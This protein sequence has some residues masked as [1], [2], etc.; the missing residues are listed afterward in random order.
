MFGA[1]QSS[2]I[3]CKRRIDPPPDGELS[4]VP[5][6]AWISARQIVLYE[7]INI[8]ERGYNG[9][10][11]RCSI[12]CNHDWFSTSF[13]PCAFQHMIRK[14]EAHGIFG[15]VLQWLSD[16]TK[17][18]VQRVV[19]N[20]VS[21]TWTEVLSSVVQG[22]VLGPVLFIVFINDIDTVNS[23]TKNEITP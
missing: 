6:P 20:G 17:H 16:W 10:G 9:I 22:S 11:W 8:F 5:E 18:R 15:K 7:L 13:R 1:V 2:G 19:L 4:F 14:L 21:S 12:W 23:C 3:H